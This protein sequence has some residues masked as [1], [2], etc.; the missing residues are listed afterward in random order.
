MRR[1]AVAFA[2]LLALWAPASLARAG[3]YTDE[4]TKCVVK[5]ANDADRTAFVAFIFSAMSVHPSVQAYSTISEVQRDELSKAVAGLTQRLLTEDCRTETVAAL[6][7][8]GFSVFQAPFS[9]LEDAAMGDLT[10]NPAVH[11]ELGRFASQLDPA[12]FLP[13]LKEAGMQAPAK[14]K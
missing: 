7:N 9:A 10:K 4:L 6:K 2:L 3:V 11:K 5:H 14:P 13:V 1:L 12:K 8:E